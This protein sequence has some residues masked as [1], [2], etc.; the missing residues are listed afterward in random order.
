LNTAYTTISEPVNRRQYDLFGASVNG[1]DDTFADA[2]QKMFDEFL[3]GQ[4]DTLLG[5]VD[6]ISSMNPDLPITKEGTRVVLQSMREICLW[7][8][9]LWGAAKFEVIALYE[10]H[11]DL[12]AL[13]F[14]D[15]RGR[16]MKSA[17]L[18]KGLLSLVAKMMPSVAARA[19]EGSAV[20]IRRIDMFVFN[21]VI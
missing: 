4:Y 1:G 20:H 17:A 2:V 19:M 21:T 13:P 7:G 18:S 11:V 14:F 16:L 5:L 9:N 10:I 6:Q 3:D 15:F 8:G 12:Q